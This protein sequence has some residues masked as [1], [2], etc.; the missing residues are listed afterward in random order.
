M[1]EPIEYAPVDHSA[2]REKL[3]RRLNKLLLWA[4]GAALAYGLSELARGVFGLGLDAT[5][6]GTWNRSGLR[7][8]M[9][10]GTGCQYV[11]TAGGGLSPRINADG[12][13]ICGG[14]AQ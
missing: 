6:A 13:P 5:D 12:S 4:A 7:L 3:A 9:D 1:A 8:H 2:E 11:S 14:A 10:Y